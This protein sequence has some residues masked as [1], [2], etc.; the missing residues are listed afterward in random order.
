[1]QLLAMV[2]AAD[3]ASAERARQTLLAK[4]QIN[5]QTP[6]L[7]PVMIKLITD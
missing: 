1:M 7:A 5:D 2:H 4:V 3:A 6:A